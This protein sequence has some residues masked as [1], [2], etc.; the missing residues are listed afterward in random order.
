MFLPLYIHSIFIIIRDVQQLGGGVPKTSGSN[1]ISDIMP[2]VT[3]HNH[4]S[5]F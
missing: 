3:P 5:K 1:S 2:D 4:Q